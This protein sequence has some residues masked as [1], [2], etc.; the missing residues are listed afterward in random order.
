MNIFDAIREI[1]LSLADAHAEISRL[2][3]THD[4]SMLHGPVCDVDA[5]KQL[6]RMVVGENEDGE[7]VKSPWIPYSQIAGTRK[8][9]SVPSKGQ[10]MT[11]L[12]P[13]G[14]Y[15]Q[16]IA[17]PFTWSNNNLS[18]SENEDEDVDTRGKTRTTQKDASF[19]R[20]VD[21]VTESLSKQSRLLTI[22]KDE[23][24]PTTVDD[25]HPWQGNKADALHSLEATKDGGFAFKVK[26][27]SD[28]HEI[29]FHPDNGITHSVNGGQHEITVHPQNGIKHKSSQRVTIEAPQIAHSGDLM[30]SGSIHSARTI[31]SVIGL[32]GPQ[33]AGVPGTPPNATTW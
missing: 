4:H 7:E 5:K 13:N 6:C 30:V 17:V 15:L 1:Q 31:Q 27:G 23:Q 22:H 18:P 10:Q 26:I 32:I 8:V 19:K 20:E 24:N 2:R 16:A 14:D 9:H 29:K 28:Q 11:M 33:I 12:S 21:G 3:W 25:A